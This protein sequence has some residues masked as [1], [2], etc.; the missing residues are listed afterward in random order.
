VDLAGL[1]A[2]TRAEVEAALR[3]ISRLGDIVRLALALV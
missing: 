2:D 3:H 1:D